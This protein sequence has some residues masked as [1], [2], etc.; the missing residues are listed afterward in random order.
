M[1]Y[2][3]KTIICFFSLLVIHG[4][5]FLTAQEKKIGQIQLEQGLSLFRNSQYKEALYEFLKVPEK[6]VD[7][8]LIFQAYLYISNIH[9][10]LNENDDATTYAKRLCEAKQEF[11]LSE[12][13]FN[14]A[15]IK[16]IESIKKEL[17]GIGYFD[18]VPPAAKILLDKIEVGVTPIKKELLAKKY[19]LRVVKWGYSPLETTINITPHDTNS[20]KFDLNLQK[21]WKSFGRSALLMFVLS[22]AMSRI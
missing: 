2:L 20:V 6:S 8:E 7:N 11:T 3:Q 12:N 5:T 10:I 19:F 22:I 4:G 16:F 18:T 17:I 21:N 14:S 9:F 1:S 13:E 15:F